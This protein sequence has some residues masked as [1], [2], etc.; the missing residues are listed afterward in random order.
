MKA[1][2]AVLVS[3][4]T[5]IVPFAAVMTRLEAVIVAEV[6]GEVTVPATLIV[7]VLLI[8]VVGD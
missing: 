7:L 6:M 5:V 3:E 8:L 2:A 1:P 4:C